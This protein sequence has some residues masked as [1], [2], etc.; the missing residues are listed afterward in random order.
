MTNTVPKILIVGGGYAGFYT[1]WKLEKHLRKGEADV[2]IVDPRTAFA[3]AER[4]P[5]IALLAE[6]PDQA[7]PKLALDRWT[8]FVALTHDPKIDDPALAAAL[9][10]NCFYVG[11]L[12][13]RKTHAKRLERLSAS[14]LGADKLARIHSP[15]GLSIGAATPGEIAIAILAEITLRKRR[16]PEAQP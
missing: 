15:V 13:S 10:A 9:A 16:G 6:W 7:L 3:T 14:G 11:A 1:A 2:T 5:D 8:A 12:G 4:F